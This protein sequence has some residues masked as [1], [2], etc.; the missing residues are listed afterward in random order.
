MSFEQYLMLLD[1]T[2]RQPH[3][4]KPGSIPTEL[5][6]ILERLN[7][8]LEKRV[9]QRTR[10]LAE[11]N[12]DLETFV[13][14]MSHDLR[15]P[16]RGMYGFARAILEDCGERLDA[17]GREYAEYIVWAAE[18]LDQLIQD[19][20]RYNQVIRKRLVHEDVDLDQTVE[21]V[22]GRLRDVLEQAAAHVEVRKPL[23]CVR[24][25]G[26]TVEQILFNLVE[27]AVKF[28]QNNNRPVV[29]ICSEIRENQ[30]VRV[31]VIDNGIG[32]APEHHRRIFRVLER[33]HGV[34]TYPGTGVGLAI[35]QRATERLGGRVGVESEPGKGS[36]FWFE[37][38]MS[39]SG[40][41]RR[42]A[43]MDAG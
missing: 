22:L 43:A 29:E 21:N 3:Q 32:I 15:A 9:R 34:E 23:G 18:H 25:H 4:D 36:C 6:P 35:V 16:L 1:W 28:V 38:P 13:H 40:R 7:I 31:R 24:G 5:R 10:E 2:G 19:L 11:R 26:S 33:L 41:G 39:E 30:W 42:G 20:L 37:L 27:N 8:V 12:A 14:S 17:R